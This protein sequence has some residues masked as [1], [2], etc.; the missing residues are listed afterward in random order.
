MTTIDVEMLAIAKFMSFKPS[1]KTFDEKLS[2]A[3]GI[4]LGLLFLGGG[5]L[6]KY[7]DDNEQAT[8]QETQGAIVETLSRRER[9]KNN[10]EKITYAPVVEFSVQ[11]EKKRFTG[12][13]GS[14]RPSQGKSVVVRYDPKNPTGKARIVP[15]LEWLTPW[16]MFGMGGFAVVYNLALLSP[17]QWTPDE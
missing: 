4:F 1:E 9:D 2:A 3:I 11:G 5:C 13:Y 7:L 14:D 12:W 15:P 17:V 6:V 8:L 16:A 10:Q